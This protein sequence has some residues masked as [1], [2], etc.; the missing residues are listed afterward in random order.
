MDPC[1]Y[2]D[3]YQCRPLTD[4]YGP[5]PP[6]SLDNDP[7]HNPP[8]PAEYCLRGPQVEPAASYW[9]LCPAPCAV[10][11]QQIT[12][13]TDNPDSECYFPPYPDENVTKGEVAELKDLAC[14]RD[15]PEAL[16]SDR[17][18]RERKG[19]SLFLRLRPQPLGAVINTLRRGD[20][21]LINGG[22]E[23]RRA[24]ID[25]CAQPRPDM[26]PIPCA[27]DCVDDFYPVVRTGRELARYFESETP[28][29]AHR[30]ALNY[31]LR[32]SNYSPPYQAFI[33][34]ALDVAIYSA[35][36]AAWYYKWIADANCELYRPCKPMSQYK[37]ERTSRRPRP[38]EVDYEVD[39]LFNRAVNCTG[40]GD[41]ERRLLPDPSPGTPRHPSY[42]SGHST[43]SGAASEILSYFFPDYSG[44][45]TK[46]A[47]NTGL[48]RLWAGI[49]YRSDHIEGMKLGRCVA[50]LVIRQ[51]EDSCIVRPDPCE[52][53][54]SSVADCK[55]GPPS[56]E[57]LCK[58]AQEFCECCHGG[59][60]HMTAAAQEGSAEDSGGSGSSS[61]DVSEQARGPQEG[62][63]VA[64][65][66]AEQRE[67]AQGPQEG[68]GSPGSSGRAKEQAQG[69]QE[70]AK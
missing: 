12:E 50:R 19:L 43:Y 29:L 27:T 21:L 5:W 48:A 62:A 23:L 63:G 1:K 57:R 11:I 22:P 70:G 61:A 2:D 40:S 36:G 18:G 41:G 10:P 39:V 54:A 51:I 55:K 6:P 9:L 20:S 31:L 28:G 38:Y 60:D 35:L 37:R 34:A 67:Q 4:P 42:P 47:D 69:P 33:W 17:K 45:F 49:H 58:C 65:S 14:L 56:R 25:V 68:A 66:S 64:G 59:H 46:L 8:P 53:A 3:D 16:F 13:I 52:S 32:Q 44:E 15:E 26:G 30:L 7:L 24:A